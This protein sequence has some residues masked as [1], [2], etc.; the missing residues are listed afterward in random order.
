MDTDTPTKDKF[1]KYTMVCVSDTCVIHV[2]D[3]TRVSYTY[4][5]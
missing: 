4:P 1:L 3:V 5:T 2:S